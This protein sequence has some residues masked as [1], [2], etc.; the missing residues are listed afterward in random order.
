GSQ[1]TAS[2]SLLHT[3]TQTSPLSIVRSVF[4]LGIVQF[5]LTSPPARVADKS[6]TGAGRFKEGGCGAPGVPHP[7]RA[8]KLSP[9]ATFPIR[10]SKIIALSLMEMGLT[11]RYCSDQRQDRV[12]GTPIATIS[13][14]R[15]GPATDFSSVERSEEHEPDIHHKIHTSYKSRRL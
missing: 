7:E 4:R 13:S 15:R 10:F 1:A 9:K 6:R 5:S 14:E 8:V 2:L 11:A 3:R 12:I